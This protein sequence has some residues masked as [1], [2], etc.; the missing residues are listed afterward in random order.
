[1][2]IKPSKKAISFHHFLQMVKQSL[3]LSEEGIQESVFYI[4]RTDTN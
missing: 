1:M 3:S 2:P 4:Y